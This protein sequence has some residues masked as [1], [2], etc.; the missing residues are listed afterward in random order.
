MKYSFLSVK[1][2]P[3]NILMVFTSEHVEMPANPNYDIV[4]GLFISK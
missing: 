3:A 1:D 2:Q 4:W